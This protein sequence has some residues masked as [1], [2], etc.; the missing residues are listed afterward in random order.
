ME[1]TRKSF[2]IIGGTTIV[3]WYHFGLKHDHYSSCWQLAELEPDHP[4][5][6][7]V[8]FAPWS[9]GIW[10]IEFLRMVRQTAGCWC[11]T[12][13]PLADM[14]CLACTLPCDVLHATCNCML[15]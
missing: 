4:P 12:R 1:L 13:I 15:R 5:S 3:V 8:A 9:I 2:H 11:H 6:F 10:L 7:A 14:A